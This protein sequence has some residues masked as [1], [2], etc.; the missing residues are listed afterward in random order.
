M[1]RIESEIEYL[2]SQLSR[3]HT[4]IYDTWDRVNV[5]LDKVPEDQF[6]V[7][8]VIPPVNGQMIV[9]KSRIVDSPNFLISF[10]GLAELDFDGDVNELTLTKEK[11]YAKEF[12]SLC[13]AS[14]YFEPIERCSYTD[15]FEHLDANVTGVILEV[16]LQERLGVSNCINAG[17]KFPDPRIFGTSF[18][19]SFD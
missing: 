17:I 11:D 16:N 8:V 1:V 13:N 15:V 2:I 7:A 19:R 4:Y 6:P 9:R 18:D 12:I 10:L 5:R 3:K 14:G